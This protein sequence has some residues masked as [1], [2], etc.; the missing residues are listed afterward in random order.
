MTSD[1]VCKAAESLTN[2]TNETK[3]TI[4]CKQKADNVHDTYIHCVRSTSV[5][6]RIMELHSMGYTEGPPESPEFYLLDG[7]EINLD[8]DVNIKFNSWLGDKPTLKFYSNMDSA[9]LSGNLEPVDEKA[10]SKDTMFHGNLIY[11]IGNRPKMLPYTGSLVVYLPKVSHN[12][13]YNDKTHSLQQNNIQQSVLQCVLKI[14][15]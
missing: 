8:F 5:K 7:D 6:S 10:Q 14:Y 4:I 3:V 12:N 15:K 9:R 11:S 1:E 13:D 2:H